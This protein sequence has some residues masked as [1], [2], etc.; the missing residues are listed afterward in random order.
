MP[1]IRRKRKLP[2]RVEDL[3]ST[4]PVTIDRD[5]PLEKAAKLMYENNIGS[6]IVV[7]K[8]G[9]IEGILT[10]RDLVFAIARGKIGRNMPVW[11]FMTEN[12]I[13][14]NPGTPIIDALKTMREANIRHLPVVD[15]EGKPVGMLSLRDI[16]EAIVVLL[17][18]P[19]E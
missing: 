3:M 1:F 16:V 11:M 9:R 19:T 6:V 7:G 10:E 17:G 5:E 8:D 2:L 13:T 18:V 15:K 12:P 14:V 4:P